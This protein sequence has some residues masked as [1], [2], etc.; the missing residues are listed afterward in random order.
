MAGWAGGLPRT[1]Y[2]LARLPAHPGI[3]STCDATFDACSGAWDRP[4]V[5]S[6]VSNATTNVLADRSQKLAVLSAASQKHV[7][8]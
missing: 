2:D 1:V 3:V 7:R 5:P 8:G 4:Y 6:P